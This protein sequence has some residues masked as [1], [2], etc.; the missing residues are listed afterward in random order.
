M[1]PADIEAIATA[2]ADKVMSRIYWLGAYVFVA[3]ILYPFLKGL[4]L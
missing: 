2:T 1:S 3:A 4:P